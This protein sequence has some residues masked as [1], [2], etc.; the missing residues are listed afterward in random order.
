MARRYRDA[1]EALNALL[2]M[3]ERDPGR[4]RAIVYPDYDRMTSEAER[5][6]FPRVIDNAE[7]AQAVEVKRDRRA[8]PA[9]I[10]FVALNDPVRLNSLASSYAAGDAAQQA[11]AA[12]RA[13]V[14]P[15]PD[16]IAS[17]LE[18]IAAAWAVRRQP[19]PGLV[20]GD[21]H[22]ATKFLRILCA[23]DRR[24]YQHGWDMRTFSRRACGDSKAVE[25]GMIRLTQV[26]RGHF[27][28]PKDCSTRSLGSPRHRE[29]PAAGI[30]PGPIQPGCGLRHRRAALYRIAAGMDRQVHDNGP[31]SLCAVGREPG[32][33]QPACP[34]GCR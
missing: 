5:E 12:L 22:K 13:E 18:E 8:G 34:R 1:V 10:R 25:T 30:D 16:W 17:V 19:Y 29:I 31:G 14:G 2:D 32:L 23:I 26:L 9:D 4:L 11:I 6:A 33:I 27:W 21:V 3:K 24:D 20:P 28:P 7:V 15:L